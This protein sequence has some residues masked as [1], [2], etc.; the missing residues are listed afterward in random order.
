M[1][2]YILLTKLIEFVWALCCRIQPWGFGVWVC[3]EVGFLGV[4]FRWEV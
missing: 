3:G 1:W 2:L 4:G